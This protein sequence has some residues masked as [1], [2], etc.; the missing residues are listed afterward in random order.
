MNKSIGG[1]NREMETIKRH[2]MKIQDGKI[3]VAKIKISLDRRMNLV[4]DQN[5]HENE[6]LV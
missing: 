1:I 4:E 6:Q 5:L 3:T 2:L